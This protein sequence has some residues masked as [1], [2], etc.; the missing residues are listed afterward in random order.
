MRRSEFSSSSRRTPRRIALLVLLALAGSLIPASQAR[1]ETGRPRR[2]GTQTRNAAAPSQT[3]TPQRTPAQPRQ[4]PSPRPTPPPG[5]A[6]ST[7]DAPPPLPAQVRPKLRTQPT[8][9]P[10]A[11]TQ[12][13]SGQ[14]VD[15]DEV[16]TIDTSLVN[17]HIRVIDRDN[18]PINDVSKSD[19]RVFENGVAQ[20]VQFVSREEVPITYGLVV[21]NS[22]SLRSQIAQVVEAGKTIVES[23]KPGDETFVVRFISSDE[24]K[25]MQDFTAD[26]QA[27]GDALDDMF[28]EGGQTAVVDAV[29][30]AAEHASERRGKSGDPAEE[31]RR[32][33]LILVTDGEDR[34]SF[35]K[36][37][38]LFESLKEEDVQIYVIGFVNE[39]EKE[40]GFISKSKR[41]KAVSLLDR[42][43]H[44]TGGRTFYP[45]S[46]SELPGIAE[47]ITK[48]L[49]TQY[50]IGYRPL[51]KGR[52]GEFRPVRVA[53]A[54][55]RGGEKR[56]AVTRSG[57]TAKPSQTG[58]PQPAP[59][60]KSNTTPAGRRP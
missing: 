19:F 50:V 24:I 40:R 34:N 13:E 41:D 25:I 53:V 35:Y 22:G 2:V 16:V 43:A 3:P 57:Y 55:G 56:I 23:N 30:L 10:D 4:T 31:K 12:D 44:E 8:A 11:P 26:K 15:P 48:D 47:Q 18:R 14:Q 45:T 59:S 9:E 5:P 20:D 29:Y 38:Q 46:L 28:I 6:V 51:A 42:L 27:L 39:L 33:A 7:Q 58:A 54:D 49:R 21:D 37:E 17:L 52:P 1:Q 60:N 32:R 36:T